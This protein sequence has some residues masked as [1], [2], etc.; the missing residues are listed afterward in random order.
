MSKSKTNIE[1]SSHSQSRNNEKE[2]INFQELVST[3]NKVSVSK[4]DPNLNKD[5][6]M[7]LSKGRMRYNSIP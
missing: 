5:V 6:L 1:H 7:D 3:K 4:S 2:M